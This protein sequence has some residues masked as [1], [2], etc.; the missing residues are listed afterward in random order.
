MTDAIFK[1]AGYALKIGEYT[2]ERITSAK[3][4]CPSSLPF[5][6]LLTVTDQ[7]VQLRQRIPGHILRIHGVQPL[8]LGIDQTGHPPDGQQFCDPFLS[9]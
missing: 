1:N 7:N 2:N 9:D 6:N 8:S 5:Q 4:K 3:D